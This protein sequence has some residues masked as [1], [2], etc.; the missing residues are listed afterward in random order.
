MSAETEREERQLKKRFQDLA[1]KSY[2]QNIYTFTGFLSLAEQDILA[3][4]AAA[5][6]HVPFALEGGNDQ[7]ERKMARFG[8]EEEL[9]YEMDFPI[10]CLEIKP[11]SEKFA[12]NFSHRDFLGALMNLGIDRSTVGDI[13]QEGKRAYVYCTDTMAS[14]IC[15]N[16]TKVRHTNVVCKVTESLE[17]VLLKEPKTMDVVVSSERIDGMISKVY[18]LSRGQSIEL[19]RAKKIFVNGRQME[20]NSY[21]LKEDDSVTVRGLGKFVYRGL[22]HTTK[23]GKLCASADVFL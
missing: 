5:F 15:E 7:T 18:H 12:D 14:Y 23:K 1:E 8:S 13:F 4:A 3:G 11:L 16:L 20:N 21:T 2:S 19:F 10:V 9:G 6:P 17:E 22:R